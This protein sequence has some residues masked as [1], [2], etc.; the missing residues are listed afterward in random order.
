MTDKSSSTNL[1]RAG[2]L[3]GA[4][5]KDKALLRPPWAKDESEFISKCD[6]T[7]HACVDACPEKIIVIGRGKYPQIDFSKG[8]CTFCEQCVDACQ[9][10][11]LVKQPDSDPWN[12]KAVINMEQC[13]TQQGVVCRSCSENCEVVAI[14]FYPVIGGVSP[15]ELNT[16]LCNGCGACLSVCP[17]KALFIQPFDDVD[18][19]EIGVN[20]L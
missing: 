2:F 14:K 13:I 19:G 15:P 5:R 9:Y 11:A 6:S 1:S 8:E 12:Y 20:G 3:Q 10:G 4:W 16:D 17:S 18:Q 7:C